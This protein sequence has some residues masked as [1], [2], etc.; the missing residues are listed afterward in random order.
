MKQEALEWADSPDEMPAVPR[1]QGRKCA[2][3]TGGDEYCRR[4]RNGDTPL[5]NWSVSRPAGPQ[6][7]HPAPSTPPPYHLIPFTAPYSADVAPY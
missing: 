2:Q 1:L 4:R 7:S 5:P 3:S 6:S